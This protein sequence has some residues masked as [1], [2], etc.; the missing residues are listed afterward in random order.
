MTV[1]LVHGLIGILDYPELRRT[2]EPRPVL[3][4]DLLGYGAHAD[5]SPERNDLHAQVEHWRT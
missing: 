5:V 4:P 3:A 1:L 2:L